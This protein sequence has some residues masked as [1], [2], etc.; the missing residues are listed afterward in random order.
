MRYFIG[1]N[2]VS[3]QLEA[4][5]AKDF[6]ELVDRHLNALAP[7]GLTQ[8]EY[9][10]MPKEERDKKKRVSYL[11]P[12]SFATSP[13][14]RRYE[15]ATVC[16]LI[17]LDI[18]EGEHARP[19]VD[20]PET[21]AEQLHPFNFA[22]YHT[23][24]STP[25][26]PR[27][28]IVVD[29]EGIPKER[30]RDAVRTIASK[31]GLPFVNK[32]SM[33]AHQPMFLPS[34]FSDQDPLTTRPMFKVVWT[35][36]TMTQDDIAEVDLGDAPRHRSNTAT[37]P[38]DDLSFLR[39]PLP[40]ITLEMAESALNSLSPDLHYGEWLDMAAALKHQ[41]AH[42]CHDDAFDL[43]DRWSSQGSSYPGLGGRD[44]TEAKWDSLK[45]TPEGR[46]PKTIRTLLMRA[47]EAG[48]LRAEEVKEVCYQ[49][50]C[51]WATNI[52][53]TGMEIMAQGVGR[54][55][56]LPMSGHAEEESLLNFIIDAAKTRFSVKMTLGSLKRDLEKFKKEAGKVDA[57][58]QDDDIPPWAAGICYVTQTNE[59]YHTATREKYSTEKL[60]NTFSRNLM[61][62]AEEIA[63]SDN[64]SFATKPIWMPHEYLLNK[65]KCRLVSDYIYDP[66]RYNEVYIMD[67]NKEMVNTYSDASYPKAS[68]EGSEEA[69]EIFLEH[70]ANLIAE[71]EY[72]RIIMDFMAFIIQNP[73]I[74]IRWA[75]LLQGAQGCGKTFIS[76]A[77]RYMLGN[78]NVK[79]VDT[80]AISGNYNEW[81][82]GAQVVTIEEIRVQGKDKF[83]VMNVLKPLITNARTPI[84][85]KFKDTRT[86][87]NITN[88]FA[89]TN[90]H[91][92]IAVNN[93][94]RRYCV[95]KSRLQTREMVL[96]LGKDYFKRVFRMIETQGPALKWFFEK[97][98]I[99]KD[100]DPDGH[101]P[102]TTYLEQVIHD[103]ACDVTAALRRYV[104]EG[105]NP[106]I[107]PDLVSSAA[108]KA[109]LQL[110]GIKH[111]D[112]YVGAVLR[113]ESYQEVGRVQLEAGR[114]EYFWKKQGM[115]NHGM[116]VAAEARRRA[117]ATEEETI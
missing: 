51:D 25:E 115:L 2:V 24:S 93:D 4:S 63:D 13:A 45:P 68:E 85:Q 26:K 48:W 101:A 64:P 87:F 103:S 81:A 111:S 92:A 15:N 98:P 10:A 89:F 84:N 40:E 5:P 31:I 32:E 90:S 70:L 42:V 36:R 95:L 41:F 104:E 19:Y 107:Q 75:I 96:A 23:A 73:G 86:L 66:T 74:K 9:R 38:S 91:D 106:M 3:N 79:L 20:S 80:T 49:S 62:S 110:D 76:E 53:Q 59:F 109:M 30:Y 27:I 113:E 117:F 108:F 34:L 37:N 99:S 69:G 61:R 21:L 88:Y 11:V 14:T 116:D 29:A 114:R 60:N 102:W 46:V 35:E 105:D 100:F 7:I 1:N 94:D 28:R 16:N 78:S 57:V 112:R 50:I 54:I 67:E 43:F 33:V 39:A 6:K 47:K 8:A 82:V 97:W 55:A 56:G 12:A 71:P 44:G 65:I 77:M 17:F 52:A 22:A 58:K 83:G 18:D 72:R